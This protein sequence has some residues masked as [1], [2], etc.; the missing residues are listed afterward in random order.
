MKTLWIWT[1]RQSAHKLVSINIPLIHIYYIAVSPVYP[2]VAYPNFEL[3]ALETVSALSIIHDSSFESESQLQKTARVGKKNSRAETQIPRH[4]ITSGPSRLC[5]SPGHS[6]ISGALLW[7]ADAY[8]RACTIRYI[9]CAGHNART[10]RELK[11]GSLGSTRPLWIRV[12]TLVCAYVTVC[13]S[14][15]ACVCGSWVPDSLTPSWIIFMRG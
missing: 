4:N 8:K 5:Y 11:K 9:L 13:A 7:F 2:L 10:Q 12:R 6:K 1:H 15:C 14:A 3:Y